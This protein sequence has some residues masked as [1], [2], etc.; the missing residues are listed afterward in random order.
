MMSHHKKYEFPVLRTLLVCGILALIGLLAVR[1]QMQQVNLNASEQLGMIAKVKTDLLERWLIERQGDTEVLG[2]ARSL[3]ELARKWERSGD[4]DARNGLLWRLRDY[5]DTYRYFNVLIANQD[6]KV[7]VSV[8]EDRLATGAMVSDTLRSTLAQAKFRSGVMTTDFYV[9][10]ARPGRAFLDFVKR[11]PATA[12]GEAPIFMV[13]QTDTQE[14]LFPYLLAWPTQSKSAEFLLLREEEKGLR[15]LNQLRH[16]PDAAMSLWSPLSVK[17]VHELPTVTDLRDYRGE[18]VNYASRPVQ[19]MPWYMVVKE[20][21]SEAYSNSFWNI[22]WVVMADLMAMLM[23]I[24]GNYLLMQSQ[25]LLQ[26]KF[27]NEQQ[28]EQ[29]A[30][31]YDLRESNQRFMQI[32]HASRGWVWETDA[33]MQAFTYVSDNVSNVL[34]YAPSEL[35]GRGPF[36]FLPEGEAEF[37]AS[38]VA[39]LRA[40]GSETIEIE[41]AIRHKDGRIRQVLTIGV[42][43]RQDDGSVSGFVGTMHDVTEARSSDLKIRQLSQAVEQAS[44]GIVITDRNSVIEFANQA[45]CQSV[46]MT[47]PELLGKRAG[48]NAS[49]QT[50]AETYADLR[51]ALQA[52]EV[53]RGRFHNYHADGAVH[54]DDAVISPIRQ[55]DGRVVNYM[56]V[57]NDVTESVQRDDELG[58]YRKHL[59]QLVI[60]RTK[61]LEWAQLQSEENLKLL[62]ESLES[63][64]QGFVIYDQ[65]D[66]LLFCNSY[67]AECFDP[68]RDL[69]VPGTHFDEIIRAGVER[70]MYADFPEG[71][72]AWIEQRLR[73]HRAGESE[74]FEQNLRDGRCLLSMEFRTPS[75]YFVGNRI[76]ITE[77]KNT[78]HLL[79]EARDAAKAASQAKS[80][81]LAN[82]SHEIRSPMNAIIGLSHLC[83]NT[84]LSEKSRE[85]VGKV[86][87]SAVL[88]L[89]V[90]N[91]ILDFSKIEAGKMQIE[92]VPYSLEAVVG[93]S[94][95]LFTAMLAER[96]IGFDVQ[97]APDVPV[98]LLGDPLRVGQVITNLLSN[99]AKFTKAGKIDLSVS[100]LPAAEDGALP[101]LQV[102]VRDTGVGMTAEQRAGL[103]RV[104][105][106]A[107]SSITRQFGGTGLG[108]AICQQLLQLMGGEIS[109]DS[110]PGQGSCFSFNLP[111]VLD[112]NA[113][114]LEAAGASVIRA[115]VVD[116]Q[117]LM[118]RQ[119]SGLLNKLEIEVETVG[120]GEEALRCLNEAKLPFTLIFMDWNM[121]G[122]D[123]FDTT[124]R[125]RKIP[126]YVQTP[127]IMVT[128]A[129]LSEVEAMSSK[130][131]D[132]FLFKPLHAERLRETVEMVVGK[133]RR[134]PAPAVG[135]GKVLAGRRLLVVDDND[136]NQIVAK[137][138]LEHDGAQVDLANNGQEAINALA[139][140]TYDLVLMDMQMPV[141]D[142]ITATTEIRREARFAN[143]PIIAMTA[144]ALPEERERCLAAGMND[145]IAKPIVPETLADSLAKWLANR[146]APISEVRPVA[147]P[148][149]AVVR[150]PLSTPALAGE[151]FN[152]EVGMRY[153]RGSRPLYAKLLDSFLKLEG[154]RRAQLQQGV[155][156][157]DREKVMR[158]A[159]TMRG[160]VSTLGAEALAKAASAVEAPLKAGGSLADVR[161]AVAAFEACWDRTVREAE[162]LRERLHAEG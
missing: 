72:E 53:W 15:V 105:A 109:V 131:V 155:A 69:L 1:Y 35:L 18:P 119:L 160:T 134:S 25:R 90:I 40:S 84:D 137:N 24:V 122:L 32:T 17:S 71:D 33:G 87:Q 42:A 125:L 153:V 63:L 123:G 74:P 51:R 152:L 112:P 45:Y 77:L 130:G 91:E 103:F 129:E 161:A 115:L 117:E 52:Q 150:A 88:L 94:S 4:R 12:P 62:R 36:E 54:L 11:M 43:V 6:G 89:G 38:E 8:D 102:A 75:G 68:V 41:H 55:S 7:L 128:A 149:P 22:G 142:G 23:V 82:M 29:L 66:R 16:H 50:S 132:H 9:D 5:K 111:C 151:L 135:N 97:I 10:P 107:D 145:F 108:L 14:F 83:L 20:D 86:K 59:Q 67:Y 100:L 39:Q 65:N 70:K 118:R 80:Q 121:P 76:D 56:A 158:T 141:M 133:F 27:E 124:E 143:L 154:E 139:R 116:D 92:T 61:E 21:V 159:H 46:G 144:N 30:M 120:S 101:R 146:A 138:L 3:S 73:V 147:A 26:R 113:P 58:M 81:F 98:Y 114:T 49:G 44:N 34:G 162:S 104:F 13:L 148:T 99:A 85:Y 79:Q 64:A 156:E 31:Q 106:Q 93:Q 126:Q 28:S 2:S 37:V 157:N 136:F 127:V 78:E 48:F 47:L 96:G 110:T 60:D 95:G 140:Q 19:G 57:F